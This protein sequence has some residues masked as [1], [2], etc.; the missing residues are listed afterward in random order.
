[1]TLHTI[2]E[3]Y[4][5]IN[6]TKKSTKIVSTMTLKIHFQASEPQI[7]HHQQTTKQPTKHV[8]PIAEY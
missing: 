7:A 3:H 1:M 8:N 2:H 4:F 6:E 5:P